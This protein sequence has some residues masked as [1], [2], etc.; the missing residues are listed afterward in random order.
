[1]EHF[2]L[3]IKTFVVVKHYCNT[4]T[5]NL[6]LVSVVLLSVIEIRL[7]SQ[8]VKNLAKLNI[9]F[10]VNK[11]D[12]TLQVPPV[13]GLD[14]TN[15]T[16]WDVSVYQSAVEII[17]SYINGTSCTQKQLPVVKTQSSPN[18][19]DETYSCEVCKRVFVG[20]FQWN[21]H[22]RSNKH[23]R[24]LERKNKEERAI[25]NIDNLIGAEAIS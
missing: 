11:S 25:I 2:T 8:S 10:F 9:S 21:I 17:E 4:D 22:R 3:K 23:K 13:Y 1:M 12:G 24:M 6:E 18:A 16:D 7:S 14:T 5:A 19:V 20:Q 15:V